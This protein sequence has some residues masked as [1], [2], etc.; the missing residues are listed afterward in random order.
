MLTLQTAGYLLGSFIFGF[1]VVAA[2]KYG[3][4]L[5]LGPKTVVFVIIASFVMTAADAVSSGTRFGVF[6]D[7]ST[8]ILFTYGFSVAVVGHF[9]SPH[10]FFQKEFWQGFRESIVKATFSS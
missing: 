2:T 6:A 10:R 9:F 8:L 4:N 5:S 1:L 7:F 3:K